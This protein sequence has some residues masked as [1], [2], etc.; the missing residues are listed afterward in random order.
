[1]EEKLAPTEIYYNPKENEEKIYFRDNIHSAELQN[2]DEDNFVNAFNQIFNCSNFLSTTDSDEIQRGIDEKEDDINFKRN[3][4]IY[5]KI[6][7]DFKTNKKDFLK[8]SDLMRAEQQLNKNI[9]S[10]SSINLALIIKEL[11]TISEDIILP[12]KKY[13]AL[14][15]QRK[16]IKELISRVKSQICNNV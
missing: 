16:L 13:N 7:E 8:E 6:E 15:L 1:M 3:N 5:A 4:G 11:N 14:L 2:I 9:S 10:I 12:V